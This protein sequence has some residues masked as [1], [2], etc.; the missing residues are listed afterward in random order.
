MFFYKSKVIISNHATKFFL[1]HW[2][3]IQAKNT[4]FPQISLYDILGF[5]LLTL[6]C[7]YLLQPV[8]TQLSLLLL[9]VAWDYS[10]GWDR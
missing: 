2:T 5:L 8:I 4:P 3:K 10:P 6:V 7:G 1:A 9:T